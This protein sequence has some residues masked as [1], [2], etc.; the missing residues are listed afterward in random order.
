MSGIGDEWDPLIGDGGISVA[1]TPPGTPTAGRHPGARGGAAAVPGGKED[2]DD[3]QEPAVRP[4]YLDEIVEEDM[5]E[6]RDFCT[7][8]WALFAEHDRERTSLVIA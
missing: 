3:H 8:D 6:V 5:T 7:I 4:I 2:D 1:S